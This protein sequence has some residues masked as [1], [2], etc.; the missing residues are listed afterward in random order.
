MPRMSWALAPTIW[1]CPA[2][3]PSSGAVDDTTR[4]LVNDLDLWL[5]DQSGTIYY[6]W[7]LNPANPGS[8]AVQTRANHIDN[9]E[10]VEIAL[11]AAGMYTI[12]VGST[13]AVANQPYSL[14]I[15][16][17]GEV[18]PPE[19]V[20]VIPQEGGFIDRGETLSIAPR[21]LILRFNEGQQFIDTAT[22][23]PRDPNGWLSGGRDGIQVTRSVNGIWGDG[24]DQVV[25][26][27]WIGIGDRPNDV[28]LRFAESLPDDLYRISIIGS[29]DYLGPDDQPVGPLTNTMGLTFRYGQEVVDEHFAFELDL[30][31]QVTAVVPQPIVVAQASITATSGA[32]IPDGYRFTVGEW[33]SPVGRTRT[34]RLINSCINAS[35]ICRRPA[36]SMIT[37]L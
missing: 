9:V 12:H 11:P 33:T 5:E 3:G 7:T 36:V 34:R 25:P 21:E 15:S 14:L 10:Q 28:V 1:A 6:P 19:L 29:D 17:Y 27:G 31:A 4:R 26:I 18:V 32:N 2:S 23:P 35:S 8:P 16:N 30:G 24:D 13:G 20:L 22:S 37:G